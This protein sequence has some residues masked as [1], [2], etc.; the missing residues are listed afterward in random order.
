MFCQALT[1]SWKRKVSKYFV[2]ICFVVNILLTSFP[3]KKSNAQRPAQ[4]AHLTAAPETAEMGLGGILGLIFGL[5]FGVILVAAAFFT[6][7]L[8][9]VLFFFFEFLVFSLLSQATRE[10]K[11]D[12]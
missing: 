5:L 11:G 7:R 4:C 1:P 10:T 9:V 2:H 8:V 12:K 3:I 6:C